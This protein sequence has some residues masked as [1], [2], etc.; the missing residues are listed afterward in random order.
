VTPR[1]LLAVT[2]LLGTGHL[3]RTALIAEALAARGVATTLVSG[4]MP[5]P[6]LAAGGARIV[7]LPPL[8]AV[9][10]SFARLVDADGRG[11]D[12]ALFAAR[13]ARLLAI[14]AETAP[15][16][17]VVEQYPF[18]RRKLAGEFAS[19]LDAARASGAVTV[20]SVRDVVQRS[21]AKRV[22]E[23]AAVAR[24]RLDAV[25][26]HGDP[27][28]IPFGASFPAADAIAD[29]LVYTGYV[30]AHGQQHDPHGP[31]AGE[32]IV[33]AG[34]GAVGA[35]LLRTALDA[36]ALDSDRIWRVLTGPGLAPDEAERLRATAPANAIVEPNRTDFRRLLANCAASVSQ[37]GYNTVVDVLAARTR[38]VIVPFVADGQT[39]QAMRAHRLAALGLVRCIDEADLDPPTLAYAVHQARGLAPAD[40]A[41][42]DL[43]GAARSATLLET[44]AQ[45]GHADVERAR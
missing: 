29:R 43:D 22:A 10:A 24:G 25:L 30:A 38:G 44:W 17:V 11:A 36:A 32:V 45:V 40:P 34:G 21:D 9:D 18:G 41:G 31:G 23:M 12:D 42:I 1:V 5:V 39:E 33:S 20:G 13:R 26:V 8:R 37:G 6:G 7:A 27:R 28:V 2:H 14:L 15:H 4:G 35:R 3:V 19:L 16:V